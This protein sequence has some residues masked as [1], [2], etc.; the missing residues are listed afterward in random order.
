MTTPLAVTLDAMH[1]NDNV[2]YVTRTRPAGRGGAPVA[3]DALSVAVGWTFRL[4]I[5][6]GLDD[7]FAPDDEYCRGECG[8]GYW[9]PECLANAD[10]RTCGH[11]LHY[12]LDADQCR[13]ENSQY[14]WYSLD[15]GA[16]PPEPMPP[17]Y[18]TTMVEDASGPY[19]PL[20]GGHSVTLGFHNAFCIHRRNDLGF[21]RCHEV[22]RPH[23]EAAQPVN[24]VRMGSVSGPDGFS[25]CKVDSGENGYVRGFSEEDWLSLPL[26]ATG[27]TTV[28]TAVPYPA[29][30]WPPGTPSWQPL[31]A[32]AQSSVDPDDRARITVRT[33]AAFAGSLRADCGSSFISMGLNVVEVEGIETAVVARNGDP[34]AV[35]NAQGGYP[36]Q[37]SG[38]L[39]YAGLADTADGK[40]LVVRAQDAWLS[41]LAVPNPRLGESV[42]A[43]EAKLPGAWEFTGGEAATPK[44]VRKLDLSVPGVTVFTAR[45]GVSVKKLTVHVVELDILGDADHDGALTSADN[46]HVRNQFGTPGAELEET[47]P[48]QILALPS[49]YDTP[50]EVA[51]RHVPI[52]LGAAGLA[53]LS[54]LPQN[55]PESP[56]DP[57]PHLCLE[58][59]STLLQIYDA[60]GGTPIEPWQSL[61]LS[62]VQTFYAK[63]LMPTDYAAEGEKRI[64]LHYI[65]RLFSAS[66]ALIV[67]VLDI[68]PYMPNGRYLLVN[69]DNDDMGNGSTP[70]NVEKDKLQN[71]PLGWEDDELRTACFPF[72]LSELAGTVDSCSVSFIIEGAGDLNIF[73]DRRKMGAVM[74]QGNS[75]VLE[76]RVNTLL[77]NF[78]AAS[79]VVEVPYSQYTLQVALE[80]TERSGSLDGTRLVAVWQVNQQFLRAVLPLTILEMR[81]FVDGGKHDEDIAPDDFGTLNSSGD[82]GSY[83]CVFWPNTDQ[84]ISHNEIGLV[85]P[86]GPPWQED[87]CPEDVDDSNIPQNCDDIHI[88][89]R[90][91]E[92]SNPVQH[93]DGTTTYSYQPPQDSEN[94]CLRDLEDF[95]RIHLKLD[96]VFAQMQNV[97]FFLSGAPVNIFEAVESNLTYLTVKSKATEQAEKKRLLEVVSTCQIP[98]AN[99][100]FNGDVS[101]FIW[102]GRSTCDTDLTLMVIIDDCMAIGSKKVRIVLKDI[103]CFFDRWTSSSIPYSGSYSRPEECSELCQTVDDYFLFVHGFNVNDYEKSTWPATAYKRLWWQ[104]FKGRLGI[105]SWPCRTVTA[106]DLLASLTNLYDDSDKTAHESGAPLA[107]LLAYLQTGY[108]TGKVH[109]LAHSQ[110]N[111]VAGEGLRQL[112][113]GVRIKTYIASQAAISISNYMPV[114]QPYFEESG[115]NK[116]GLPHSTPDV[117][118]AFP[119]WSPRAPYLANIVSRHK[120]QNFYNF[121]NEVDYALRSCHLLSW[122]DDNQMHPN[123]GYSYTGSTD[124]Y[125]ETSSGNPSAF[126]KTA[127]DIITNLPNFQK[128]DFPQ[129][130]VSGASNPY[131]IAMV[132]AF[133]ILSYAA[134][135]WGKPMGIVASVEGFTNGLNLRSS[136]LFY[137]SFHYSHSR[138]FRSNIVDEHA[139]WHEVLEKCG[140]IQQQQQ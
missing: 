38:P 5:S 56:G 83:R 40:L 112:A 50:Q 29:A 91:K 63:G 25:T 134:E 3:F 128:L 69:D 85:P 137:N 37:N 76:P 32:P 105:F 106:W 125:D 35:W 90:G 99:L 68:T 7:E 72:K 14:L 51:A 53:A 23:H 132:D 116:T 16:A 111:I 4:Y 78:Q 11:A 104:G 9:W 97:K 61:P 127:P 87:D 28:F 8:Y 121:Y 110:G 86:V 55:Q 64:T 42:P 98:L 43:A 58:F 57:E 131:D 124:T 52:R 103:S 2:L 135:A 39:Q 36:G 19:S 92:P 74:L 113:L 27:A 101:P 95:N 100:K 65:S 21:G 47:R 130:A 129:P 126:Y 70:A 82:F 62:T 20:P 44:M 45:C 117:R 60:P 119:G 66:D 88:G 54:A 17:A 138:Q 81:M 118:A 120:A 102:E 24:V 75:V 89:R 22:V 15:G 139:Y 41:L 123:T 133:T 18:Y 77:P 108:C 71:G 10:V 94:Y 84:D 67:T 96:P 109:M 34:A 46:G 114:A 48:G 93:P 59:D 6:G 33:D 12:G 30:A 49:D 115:Y 122:E 107:R 1:G 140:L 80:G 136:S 13:Q 73:S 26:G 31:V 79:P